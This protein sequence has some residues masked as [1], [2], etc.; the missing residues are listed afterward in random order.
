MRKIITLFLIASILAVTTV[1]SAGNK[2]DTFSL[3]PVVGGISYMAEQHLE[4]APLFGV[5]AGYNFTKALG[6]EA[7]FDYSRTESTRSSKTLD[8]YRY[9]GDLLYHFWPDNKFVPYLAAGY[10]GMNLKGNNPYPGTSK[11][12]GVIDYGL[13]F[14]YFVTED[15]AWRADVRGLTYFY[16]GNDQHAIE[17]TTGVYIPFGG[18]PAVSKLA[19][20]P[21]PP[22]PVAKPVASPLLPAPLATLTASPASIIKGQNSTL[23][24]KSQNATDC[25]ILPVVGS[26]QPQGTTAVTPDN[27]TIYT[28]TCK[29]EGGMAKSTATVAV[30]LPPPPVVVVPT[31][32]VKRFCN[33]PA[34]LMIN[35]DTNKY[36]IKPKYHAELKTVGDF[37]KEVPTSYGEISGH[38]DSTY[39][40]AFNQKL[41]ERRANSVKEY[42]IK[43]FGIAAERLT[44]KGYGK[45]KPIATN[46]TKAGRAKNRRIE[47]NFVC[48]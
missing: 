19:D 43:N 22:A 23:T 4:T 34:I 48:E 1:A 38:T 37:L 27:N 10:A 32:A 41:S 14:K 17:Y 31:A 2:A 11:T 40:R 6:I 18:T 39:T 13:G 5:R 20:P 35:F 33:K 24:W 47:A 29:G 21:P 30:T 25:E 3:S 12:K 28:L 7:L 46:K 15:M 36:N 26:V 42:I 44:S 8:F 45:D 9:G 16:G